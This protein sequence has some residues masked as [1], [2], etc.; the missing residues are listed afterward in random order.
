[1]HP[2]EEIVRTAQVE[3]LEWLIKHKLTHGEL[4]MLLSQ[5]ISSSAKYRIRYER[6]GDGDT[7]GGLE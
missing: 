4:V 3:F 6:H 7:Q 2:R 5:E 1:M